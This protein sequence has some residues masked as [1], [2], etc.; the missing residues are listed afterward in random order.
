MYPQ[1]MNYMQQAPMNMQRGMMYDTGA[2]QHMVN[3]V[4]IPMQAY[5]PQDGGQQTMMRNAFM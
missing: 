3:H 1:Q 4:G 5:N 2:N